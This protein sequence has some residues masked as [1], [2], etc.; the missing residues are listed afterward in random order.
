MKW[1]L[2]LIGGIGSNTF[3]AITPL[4]SAF[5][6]YPDVLIP[7]KGQLPSQKHFPLVPFRVDSK[8]RE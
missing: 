7:F 4:I 5:K 1:T 2:R 6:M 8:F 3:T